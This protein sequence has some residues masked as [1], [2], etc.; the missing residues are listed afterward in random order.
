M[1]NLGHPADAGLARIL[2][3]N[4]LDNAWKFTRQRPQ[5]RIEVG[6]TRN[7]VYFVRDNGLGFDM[8]YVDR[9]FVPF[10]RL[11]G[12]EFEGTGIGLAIAKRVVTR[13]GGRI[14]VEAAPDRGATFYFTLAPPR[15]STPGGP[16]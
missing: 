15:P 7:G 3:T 11:H 14:W 16:R 12:T 9:L 2:L 1:T 13:H 10:H 6:R 8:E 4:L 5:A